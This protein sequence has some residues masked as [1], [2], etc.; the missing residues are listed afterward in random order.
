MNKNPTEEKFSCSIIELLF[1]SV[2]AAFAGYLIETVTR[3]VSQGIID[4]RHQY[5]PFLGAYGFAVLVMYA[6]FDRPSD[7]RFFRIK[8]FPRETKHA[9]YQ[10]VAVYYATMFFIV[11]FGELLVGFLFERLGQK[12]WDYTDIPLHITQYTSIPTSLAFAAAAVVFMQFVFSWLVTLCK[13]IP[14]KV[15]T[16]LTVVLFA[17]IVADWLQ[18]ILRLAVTGALPD[19]WAIHLPWYQ[20]PDAFRPAGLRSCFSK[21]FHICI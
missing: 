12:A 17:L 3:A 2:I 21:T 8:I 4:D 10:R 19:F 9:V 18:M 1:T 5:L 13:K 16:P 15:L 11:T 7:M 20:A 14:K 6:V